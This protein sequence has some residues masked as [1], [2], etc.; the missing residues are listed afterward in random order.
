MTESPRADLSKVP[1]EIASMFDS[2]ASRYDAMDTL[3]T[4][5]LNNVWMTALRKAVAPHPGER[6]LDLAAGTGTSSASLAK[7]GAEVVA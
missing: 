6:I 7:G 2:V 1:E 5:G 3:M 4:G